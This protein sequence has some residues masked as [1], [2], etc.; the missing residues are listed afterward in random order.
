MVLLTCVIGADC[1]L[2]ANTLGFIL[3]CKAVEQSLE[4]IQL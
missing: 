3:R 1:V 4:F 2:N